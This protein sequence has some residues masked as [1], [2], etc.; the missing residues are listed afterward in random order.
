MDPVFSQGVLGY[1]YWIL[2]SGHLSSVVQSHRWETSCIKSKCVVEDSHAPP[3]SDCQC[4][5]YAYFETKRLQQAIVG[6]FYI[7]DQYWGVDDYNPFR[8]VMGIVAGRGKTEI[9]RDGFRSEEMQVL[10]LA[11]ID[12]PELE[13]IVSKHP[14]VGT[15]HYQKE[16]ARKKELNQLVQKYKV[17]KVEFRDLEKVGN[18]LSKTHNLIQG[19]NLDLPREPKEKPLKQ[20]GLTA[21]S[22]ALI[23]AFMIVLQGK[24]LFLPLTGP[25]T[26]AIIVVLA[27]IFIFQKG[28]QSGGAGSR[29]Q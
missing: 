16:L 19:K 13:K 12:P 17:Q 11:T 28:R 24:D 27:A 21:I 14:H 22:L 10:A 2:R 1:R 6:S 20:I 8:I 5:A 29:R 23:A 26:A 9:Y 15:L 18:R 3:E 25:V 7:W 4:G